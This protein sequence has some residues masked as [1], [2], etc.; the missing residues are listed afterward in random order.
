VPHT[1][2]LTIPEEEQS[3][4]LSQLRRGRYGLLLAL[5]ILLLC[6][7][8]YSPTQIQAVLFCSRS[9]VY[10]IVS[11]YKQEGLASLCDDDQC[12]DQVSRPRL[13]TRSIKRSL[14]ALLKQPPRLLGWCRT[15]WSCAT[16]AVQ[17]KLSRGISVSAGTVRN[18]LHQIGY[19][20]KRTKLAA[21]DDDP[22]RVS[23]L[24]KIR[25]IFE[26]LQKGEVLLF[27]DELDVN[28]LPKPGYGWMPKGTQMEVMTPGQ[29]EKSY[30]GGALN[31]VTGRIVHTIWSSKNFKLFID[32][33]LAISQ[34][35]PA[36]RFRRIHVVVDNVKIHKSQAVTDWLAANP[37]F[38]LEFL[39]RYCPEANPI[40]RAFGDVH[41][42]CTRNHKRRRLRDLILDV[43]SHLRLNGPWNY[44][45]P[46]IYFDQAVS[47]EVERL[48]LLSLNRRV[49]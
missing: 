20:W 11:R 15:G 13:L 43:K 36:S 7:A 1:T 33:L 28:L 45:L 31:L 40:E 48:S 17:L 21:K 39:P 2:I 12:P 10:R 30:L 23:K 22:E 14:E 37:R 18:W 16:L 8:G 35:Y 4:M 32:L 9:S 34:A 5:H 47:A 19:V 29:N 6:A 41:D 26:N 44:K 42:K 3:W 25:F 24:A 38:R 46:D 49:A 27:A